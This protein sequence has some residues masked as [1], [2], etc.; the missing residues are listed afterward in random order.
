[1]KIA[2]ICLGVI[3]LGGIILLVIA[4]ASSTH[5]N[6]M[7]PLAFLCCIVAV[8]VMIVLG[9][10]FGGRGRQNVQA[11]RENVHQAADTQEEADS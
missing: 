6:A 2:A 11:L 1:V 10:T 8:I 4:D 9:V 3:A 5:S 7:G